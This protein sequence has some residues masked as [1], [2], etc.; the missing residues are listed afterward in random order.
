MAEYL[1]R[2]KASAKDLVD[3]ACLA[4]LVSSYGSGYVE[5]LDYVRKD[6]RLGQRI[7]PDRPFI[8]AQVR[9]AV[10]HEMAHSVS[11]IALRRT[12][13]GNMG[14]KDLLVG[15]AIAAELQQVL[16]LSAEAVEKQLAEYKDQLAID[17][18]PAPAP[19]EA[20]AAPSAAKPA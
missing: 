5:V 8:L 14:D 12:D 16:G 2:Q 20:A 6:A 18:S 3:E 7:A 4:E 19:A 15:K 17:V 10:E 13:A 11:D 1:E 9:H